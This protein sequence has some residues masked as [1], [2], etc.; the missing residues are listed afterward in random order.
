MI[1]RRDWLVTALVFLALVVSV[2]ALAEVRVVTDRTGVYQTTRVVLDGRGGGVWS[3]VR[4]TSSRTALNVLGD[5]NGDFFPTIGESSVA[6]HHPWVVWS[7]LYESQYDLAWSHWNGDQWEPIGWIE[8]TYSPPGDD[9]DADLS[10][11]E[12][13][14]P[15]VVWW[16]DEDGVGRIYLSIYLGTTWMEAYPVSDLG[17]DSRYP[18]LEVREGGT[19]LVRFDTPEGEVEQTVIFDLPVTITEDINPLDFVS[20]AGY[21]VLIKD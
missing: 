8:P 5:Q 16:R 20:N 12:I 3:A 15:Y 19:L 21:A 17:V 18:S 7:R 2:Q 10:F 9:L 13:G 14:R 11:D 4:H 6:P 1:M